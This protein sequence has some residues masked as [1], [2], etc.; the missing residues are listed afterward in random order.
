[1]CECLEVR[2]GGSHGSPLLLMESES[3][4]AGIR[5]EMAG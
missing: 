5:F 3:Q 2:L 4:D 1:M